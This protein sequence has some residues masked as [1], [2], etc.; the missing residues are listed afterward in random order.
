VVYIVNQANKVAQ[1]VEQA[2]AGSPPP[3]AAPMPQVS[4]G[5]ETPADPPAEPDPEAV[6]AQEALAKLRESLGQEI[7]GFEGMLQE[8]LEGL[9]GSGAG[10]PTPQQLEQ[11]KKVEV[12]SIKLTPADFKKIKVT[13]TLEL[14]LRNGGDKVLEGFR[15]VCE[16]KSPDRPI[17]WGKE[18]VVY[19]IPGGLLPGET[20]TLELMMQ[21][22]LAAIEIPKD[23]VT[24]GTVTRA[25][26]VEP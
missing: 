5:G 21:G 1:Q 24:T 18:T 19:K 10:Q 15:M 6:A 3:A 20:R 12:V 13:N 8:Q 2:V 26:W 4:E 9:Q 11:A 23:A 17:A 16:L 7:P 22:E 25:D 14:E